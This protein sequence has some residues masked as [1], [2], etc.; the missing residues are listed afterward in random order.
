MFS[1][2]REV[3]TDVLTLWVVLQSRYI[4]NKAKHNAK[5]IYY[6]LIQ[7]GFV[8]YGLTVNKIKHIARLI[9]LL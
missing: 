8:N 3:L 9:F 4:C 6:D 1:M 2:I 5:N 7:F